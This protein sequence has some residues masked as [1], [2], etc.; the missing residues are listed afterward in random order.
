MHSFYVYMC[1]TCIHVCAYVNVGACMYVCIHKCLHINIHTH[2]YGRSCA[3]CRRMTC[4]YPFVVV[5]LRCPLNRL[6]TCLRVYYSSAL[7]VSKGTSVEDEDSPG[8]WAVPS[9]SLRTRQN[10]RAGRGPLV[11]AYS[12]FSFRAALSCSALFHHDGPKHLKP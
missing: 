5:N 2:T 7:G 10:T 3:L 4:A 1:I 11:Q 12:P 6:S 8:M 9:P